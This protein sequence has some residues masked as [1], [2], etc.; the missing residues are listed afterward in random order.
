MSGETERE[1]EKERERMREERKGDIGRKREKKERREDR[2]EKEKG[3]TARDEGFRD[4][5]IER[6][7]R[8][9]GKGTSERQR[10]KRERKKT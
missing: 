5:G 7:E 10:S 1:R 2:G 9:R 6:A 3:I 4:G 8:I